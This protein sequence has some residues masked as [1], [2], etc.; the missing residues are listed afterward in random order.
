MGRTTLLP[1]KILVD[2]IMWFS[3]YNLQQLPTAHR[4]KYCVTCTLMFMA[5]LFTIAR[6]WKQPRCPSSDEWIKNLRYIYTIEYYWRRKWQP[7]PVF[8]P[9]ES[10]GWR[11]LEGCSPWG[12]WGSD[13]TEQLNWT[14]FTHNEKIQIRS[15][16]IYY[17]PDIYKFDNRK[18]WWVCGKNWQSY[19]GHGELNNFNVELFE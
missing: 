18:S 7:T 5:A 9:G 14:E 10:H 1:E 11:S 17:L 6:T 3:S 4:T 19:C 13:M 12:R 8:L 2:G 15:S 16:L